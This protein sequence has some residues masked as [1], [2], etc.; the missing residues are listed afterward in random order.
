MDHEEKNVKKRKYNDD[1]LRY[2]FTSI[3]TA[4]IENLRN[5]NALFVMKF[6]QPNL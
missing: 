1:Y 5:P 4:G 2:G 3:V 6:Y